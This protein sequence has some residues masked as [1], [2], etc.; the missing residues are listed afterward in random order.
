[1]PEYSNFTR[2]AYMPLQ[3]ALRVCNICRVI[4]TRLAY[5]PPPG[6]FAGAALRAIPVNEFL[7]G[8]RDY[9]YILFKISVF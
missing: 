7:S 2:L 1:M 8:F 3:G 5:M 9:F 6:S 4:E